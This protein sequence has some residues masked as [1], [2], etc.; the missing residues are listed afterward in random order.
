MKLGIFFRSKSGIAIPIVIFAFFFSTLW[1]IIAPVWI[2]IGNSNPIHSATHAL[3]DNFEFKKT[4]GEYFVTKM[5][6]DASK[7]ELIILNKKGSQISTAVTDLLNAPEFTTNLD[8]ITSQVYNYYILGSAEAKSVSM[9]PIAAEALKA[10]TKVDPQFKKL[11]KEIDKIKPIQLK[12]NPNGPDLKKIHSLLT[13]AFTVNSVLLFILLLVYLFFARSR[14]GF[15]RTIG[16]I[17]LYIGAIDIAVRTVGT[18]IANSQIK[19][20]SDDLARMAAKIVL[21]NLTNPFLT[22]GIVFLLLGALAVGLSFINKNSETSPSP[23]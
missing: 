12:P 22:V 8:S 7:A 15:F 2:S 4:A 21:T 10:L 5:K 6:E 11:Q 19:T 20:I 13:L 1:A 14:K 17:F 18:A 23:S 16:I 3:L 9:K